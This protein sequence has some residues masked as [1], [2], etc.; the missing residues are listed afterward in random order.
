MAAQWT[1]LLL[2][3]LCG[4]HVLPSTG[5]RT[6]AAPLAATAPQET[7]T[8]PARQ[9]TKITAANWQ[10][11][12]KIIEIRQLVASIDAELKKAS[13]EI[14]ERRLE[15]CDHDQN[16]TVRRIARD[17]KGAVP[18][19][20]HYSEGQDESW[21]FHYYY[22]GAGR[23]RFV[24]A[25]ARSANGTREQLRLYFDEAGKRLWKTDKLLKGQG[26]PGCFS[27]YYDSDEKLAFDPAKDFAN[28]AGCKEAKS[29]A[30]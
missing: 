19:Y 1:A 3:T 16:F 24:L 30:K 10:Q 23:L 26:C 21:D 7:G 11:N 5:L 8:T 13:F 28:E 25:D 22:D 14:S 4:P 6:L 27:G 29:K 12:P 20:E 15:F 2:A 17:A 18:W 9:E